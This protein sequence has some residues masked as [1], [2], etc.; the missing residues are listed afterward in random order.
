MKT[1]AFFLLALT[2]SN[3]TWATV[4]Y[5]TL[6]ASGG[7]TSLV[8]NQGDIFEVTNYFEKYRALGDRDVFSFTAPDG[9]QRT[10]EVNNDASSSSPGTLTIYGPSTITL[11]T[12]WI[13]YKLTRAPNPQPAAAATTEN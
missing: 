6:D 12:Q 3:L 2:F 13:M 10:V 7:N 1:L 9:T 5:G 4:E 11:V 8:L